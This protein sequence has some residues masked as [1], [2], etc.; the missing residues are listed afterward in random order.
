MRV[1]V[2]QTPGTSLTQWRAT[3]AELDK[4]ISAARECGADLVVLPECAW[5]AYS[6]GSVS[7]Y[8]KAR[9]AGLPGADFFLEYLAR[10][11]R[12]QRIAICAG[13][14]EETGEHLYNAAALFEA[15]GRLAGSHR[16][17]FL[18]DFDHDCFVPGDRIAP[19]TT[20]FGPV[21]IMICADARLPEIPATLAYR[22]A[23]LILHPTAWVNTGTPAS[24][25]N[26]QPDF[27]IRARAAEFHVPIASASKWGTERATSF[28]GSSLICDAAGKKLVQAESTGSGVFVAEVELGSPHAT[29]ATDAER[30]VLLSV[31]PRPVGLK[32]AP[33]VEL[34]LVPAGSGQ[35]EVL[36]EAARRAPGAPPA[37][38]ILSDPGDNWTEPIVRVESTLVLTRPTPEPIDFGGARVAAIFAR[39]AATFTAA[40]CLALSGVHLVV[41]LGNDV[42]EWA[43]RARACENR[44]FAA[45]ARPDGLAV[46]DPTGRPVPGPSA[47]SGSSA[48]VPLRQAVD[49]CVADRT[50][51]LA[52]RTPALYSF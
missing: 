25:W 48:L 16:K 40:R 20:R 39:S 38:W 29:P 22:G 46:Y 34:A 7:E 26:P 6:L 3:L 4:Q 41:I 24:P 9:R 11:A 50:D 35:L 32:D 36:T 10:T 8:W 37:I 49:K 33:E 44:V 19:V 45:W 1:A 23:R 31:G 18:W 17:C 15:D 5:P 52:D 43:V 14:V 47:D 12:R 27:L 30:A 13:F 42:E 51:V 28:V 21:G 2:A